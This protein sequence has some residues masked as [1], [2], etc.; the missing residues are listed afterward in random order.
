MT[1]EEYRFQLIKA[2]NREK[3]SI[4]S[5]INSFLQKIPSEAVRVNIIIAPNQDGKG[6]F[7][8]H[9]GLNG[10]NL[11]HLNQNVFDW[12]RILEIKQGIDGFEPDVPMLNPLTTDFNVNDILEKICFEWIDHHWNEID[13]AH[14]KVAITI[15]SDY[16]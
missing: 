2:L 1:E 8:I 7:C 3:S 6:G 10:P 4:L 16:I 11:Y 12:T 9:G 13:D 5:N 15:Y 14:V